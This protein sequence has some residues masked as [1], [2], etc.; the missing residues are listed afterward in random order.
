MFVLGHMG[1]GSR[2]ASPWAAKLPR[3]WLL[4]G[5]V[6]PDLIDKPLFY[7]NVWL[8]S[9]E[10][11][12]ESLICGT[13][14]LGHTGIF[15]FLL[16]LATAAV[17]SKRKGFAPLAAVTIGAATH[18]LLD[19]VGDRIEGVSDS[20]AFKALIFPFSGSF[21]GVPFDGPVDHLR[22]HLRPFTIGSEAIGLAFLA[23]DRWKRSHRSELLGGWAARRRARKRR[24]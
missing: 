20:S 6:L 13:R 4:F 19:N 12:A 2:L 11:A 5:T 1:I 14:T 15:L 3:T 16:L 10:A 18:L 17:S 22:S 8:H 21:G 24:K 23:W 9:R 7:A